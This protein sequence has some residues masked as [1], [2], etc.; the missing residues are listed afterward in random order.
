MSLFAALIIPALGTHSWKWKRNLK[1]GNWGYACA[2]GFVVLAEGLVMFRPGAV[3][4]SVKINPSGNS[5]LTKRTLVEW[6][7]GS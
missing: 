7:C 6:M 3:A 2:K 1:Y 4:T 5:S